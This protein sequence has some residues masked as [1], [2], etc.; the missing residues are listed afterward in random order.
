MGKFVFSNDYE[1]PL[2]VAIEVAV[3]SGYLMSGEPGLNEEEM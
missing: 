1:K 2:V 3:E